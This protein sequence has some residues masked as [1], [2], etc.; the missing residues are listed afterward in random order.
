[1]KRIFQKISALTLVLLSGALLWANG[2]LEYSI[3]TEKIENAYVFENRNGTY[4]VTVK[5]KKPYKDE[6][7]KLTGENIG[8]K[9]CITFRGKTLTEAVIQVEIESGFMAV[10]KWA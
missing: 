9:L 3:S 7:A 8:K 1:M 5:L 6:F 4:S 2:A 10:G